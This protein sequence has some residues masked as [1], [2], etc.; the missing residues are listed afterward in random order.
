MYVTTG[1]SPPLPTNFL[2]SVV[3]RKLR[4]QQP[5]TLPGTTCTTDT[6]YSRRNS[7]L[8]GGLLPRHK[9]A[10]IGR[11]VVALSGMRDNRNRECG[12]TKPGMQGDGMG[13]HC[14][15]TDIL[16][17]S[18]RPSFFPFFPFLLFLPFLPHAT[19]CLPVCLSACFHC[20]DRR[21]ELPSCPS[22]SRLARRAPFSVRSPRAVRSLHA[23]LCPLGGCPRSPFLSWSSLLFSAPVFRP[24]PG[25]QPALPV[26]TGRE[27]G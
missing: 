9:V 10:G 25:A 12:R 19:T 3:R 6:G 14:E 5:R 16:I 27:K 20:L 26:T 1:A 7:S 4:T 11:A 8:R 18:R 13:R 24:L 2:T 22:V 15:A 21:I 23:V 17:R